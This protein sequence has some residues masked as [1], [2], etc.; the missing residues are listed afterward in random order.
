MECESARL[1]L[2]N[3]EPMV[4]P[5]GSGIAGWVFSNA[6][7]VINEGLEGA[8]STMLFG[9]LPGMP[10]FQAIICLPV[11]INK[12][13]RG[14]LCL[15]H[16]S[17]RSIDESLRSFVR[18]AVDHL[19]LFLENLYLRVR[20]RSLLPQGT[21]HSQGPRRYDPDTAPVPPVKNP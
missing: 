1:V 18:Q 12:S 15:A 5:V 9:K 19:A 6:P 4:L 14:V 10:D 20:L 21:V 8:P 11:Q 16:T 17:T 13:T 7:P 3:G 2:E